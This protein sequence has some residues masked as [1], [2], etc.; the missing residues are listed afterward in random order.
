VALEQ[1]QQYGADVRIF[2]PHDGSRQAESAG[3]DKERI[4]SQG[5][6]AVDEGDDV[7]RRDRQKE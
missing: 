1:W 2:A 7:E 3:E 4:Y 5:S 6:I